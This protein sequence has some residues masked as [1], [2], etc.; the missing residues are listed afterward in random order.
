M[1][2]ATREASEYECPACG[3]AIKSP[4][5]GRRRRVQCPKCREVIDLSG[6]RLARPEELIAPAPRVEEP[7]R[8]RVEALEARIAALER[9]LLRVEDP[10]VPE[11]EP[12]APPSKLRWVSPPVDAPMA[13]HFP[14]EM[15]EALLHNLRSR[16]ARSI[17]ILSP[18]DD[19]AARWRAER[20]KVIFLQAHWD[21]SGPRDGVARGDEHGLSLAVGSLPPPHDVA[22]TYLA[23]T[24]SGFSPRSLLDPNLGGDAA[25]LIVA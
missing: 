14:P 23:L 5:A 2:R 16:P 15:E 18:A 12:E 4:A 7:W 24:A 13:E 3:H 20:L 22:A 17:T 21:V 9:L 6:P 11:V 25:V 8:P 10:P 1:P 19:T